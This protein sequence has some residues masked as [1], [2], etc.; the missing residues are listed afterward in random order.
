M[1]GL[2]V[3]V[4]ED[5]PDCA[6]VLAEALALDGHEVA[7]VATAAA[8]LR[9]AAGRRPD[10]AIVDG[11]LG[12]DTGLELVRAFRLGA[13]GDFPVL[14]AT[15]MGLDEVGDGARE[16]GVDRVLVK[17]IELAVLRAAVMDLEHSR[18]RAETS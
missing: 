11:Y 14:L 5:D 15:G 7:V 8:A 17:P 1:R 9:E 2:F 10:V 18:R 12:G 3:L 13:L 6:A 4:V 16:A